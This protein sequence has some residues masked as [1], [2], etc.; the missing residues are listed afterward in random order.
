MKKL[1]VLFL[2]LGLTTIGFAQGT[3]EK[4]GYVDQQF[5]IENLPEFKKLNQEISVKSQQYEKILKGKFDEYQSKSA[6]FEKL[7]AD[8]SEQTILRDKAMELENLKKS[9]EDF[10]S[11]SMTELQNYYSKKFTPIRQKVSEAI[12]FAG[13]QKGYAFILRMDLNPDGG[14]IWPVVLYAKDSTSNLSRD[15]LKNLGVDSTAAS[16]RKTGMSQML[17]QK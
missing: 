15:I 2:F 4:I 11:S 8:K 7:V 17:K 10:E 16:T 13:R 6:A 3:T 1:T 9:Y 12:I 5:I 14:D